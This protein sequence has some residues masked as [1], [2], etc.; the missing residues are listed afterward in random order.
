MPINAR[1]KEILRGLA[2][3]VAEIAALPEQQQRRKHWMD[4]NDLKD[5]HPLVLCFPEGAWL[6]CIP[7]HTLQIE[8]PML[9][10]WETKLRMA[11]YTHDVIKD[12][13]VTDA[14]WNVTWDINT[15]GY[16]V[17]QPVTMPA[18][19]RN[20]YY[21]HPYVSMSL[22]SNSDLGAYHIDTVL[23]ERDDLKRLHQ[24]RLIV[25]HE[26]SAQWMETA[27]EL[28][29][30]ILEVRR[31][32]SNWLL[33]GGVTPQAVQLRGMENLMYDMFDAPEWVHEFVKFLAD[34]HMACLDALEEGGYLTLNNGCEWIG[35]GGLGYAT[36][37]PQPDFQSARVRCRDIWGGVEA[38]DLVGISGEMFGEF[39]LPYLKPIM[40][41]FGLSHYGCC[42]PV[43]DWL[44]ALK[45]VNNLRRASISAWADIHKCARQMCGNYVF[46]HKPNPTTVCT[47]TMDEQFILAELMHVL[48]VTKQYGCVP[49]LIMKDLHTIQ[50]DL[51]R[52]PR[53]VEIARQAVE[54]IYEG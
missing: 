43:H 25:N 5:T 35:T 47:N 23:N 28:F 54:Q 40:E 9:R 8:D 33:I 52:I 37:L 48:S 7:E 3:R 24:R 30:G 6:E 38:Q 26:T 14:V 16:G 46:S 34:D 50:H 11:I 41:R 1:D 49:E 21:V 32:L 2:L 42:E 17:E 31:R 4:H 20:V 18:G 39:F 15:T 53:W 51:T 10:S 13:Q 44:P 19:E 22:T 36:D 29:D 27:Q 45:T 12:D